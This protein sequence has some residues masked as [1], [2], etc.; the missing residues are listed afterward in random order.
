MPPAPKNRFQKY[1][2]EAGSGVLVWDMLQHSGGRQRLEDCSK[3]QAS[4]SYMVSS[5]LARA[6]VRPCL[7][8]N[9]WSRWMAEW[10]QAALW[11]DMVTKVSPVQSR[12]GGRELAL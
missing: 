9:M 12:G 3:F 11:V 5:M 10:V 8:K 4:L 2:S 7:E 6:I 1:L